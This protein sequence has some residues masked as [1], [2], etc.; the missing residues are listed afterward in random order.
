MSS[1]VTS[2]GIIVGRSGE[3]VDVA[4]VVVVGIAVVVLLDLMPLPNIPATFFSSANCLDSIGVRS[5]LK[6]TPAKQREIQF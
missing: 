2:K 6:I 4:D 3:G 1:V 5:L